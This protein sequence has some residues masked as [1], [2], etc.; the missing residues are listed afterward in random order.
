MGLSTAQMDRVLDAHFRHEA[1]D[2]VE[3]VLAILAQLPQQ[4]SA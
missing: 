2:D 1:N 4:E 3:A